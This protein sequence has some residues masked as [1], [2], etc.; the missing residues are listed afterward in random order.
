M[1]VTHY[2][3]PRR[4]ESRAGAANAKIRTELILNFYRSS[5]RFEVWRILAIAFERRRGIVEITVRRGSARQSVASGRIQ[6]IWYKNP[7]LTQAVR[8]ERVVRLTTAR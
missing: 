1:T 6:S 8:V 5:Y 3:E 4:V 7:L 2:T